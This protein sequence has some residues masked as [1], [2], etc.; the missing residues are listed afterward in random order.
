[1]ENIISA[2]QLSNQNNAENCPN[3]WGYSQWAD[4]IKTATK[5][6]ETGSIKE[7]CSR[8]AFIRKFMK[9]YL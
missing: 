3:C 9:K 8:N 7:F 5:K 4:Q 2:N 6:L 1:M